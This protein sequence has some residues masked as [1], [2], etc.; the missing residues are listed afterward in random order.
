MYGTLAMLLATMGSRPSATA[1]GEVRKGSALRR[2]RPGVCTARHSAAFALHHSCTLPGHVLCTTVL[3]ACMHTKSG[4]AALREPVPSLVYRSSALPALA[5]HNTRS[6]RAA[7][8]CNR[9]RAGCTLQIQRTVPRAGAGRLAELEAR[10]PLL[11]VCGVGRWKGCTGRRSG[12]RGPS[13][14]VPDLLL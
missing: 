9:P 7:D 14:I 4:L 13:H 2:L 5:K 10:E 6:L 3:A 12:L 8:S 11:K 1:C